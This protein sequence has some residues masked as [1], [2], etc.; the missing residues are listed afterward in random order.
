MTFLAALLA[1]LIERFFDWS[2]IRHWYWYESFQYAVLN[3][4]PKISPYAILAITIIPLLVIVLL[5]EWALR[6]ILFGFIGF[7]LNLFILMYC[8]GPKNLWADT[9]ANMNTING[10]NAGDKSVSDPLRKELLDHIFVEANRRVFAVLFWFVVLGPVGAVLYRMISLSAAEVTNQEGLLILKQPARTIEAILDWVPVRL[11]TL[12]F[13]LGGHFSKVFASWRKNLFGDLTSNEKI[14]IEC[15]NAAIH[16]DH[17]SNETATLEKNAI[18]LIDRVFIITLVII[19][20][21]VFL[22]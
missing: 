3:R 17:H 18:S 21:L 7:L 9:F 10:N 20:I 15:G 16:D 12:F 14:L 6:G 2:H 4:L 5:V 8:F 13:A 19:V 22:A 1:L 11:L